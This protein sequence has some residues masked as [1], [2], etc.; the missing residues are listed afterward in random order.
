[1]TNLGGAVQFIKALVRV[2]GGQD[3]AN[4]RVDVVLLEPEGGGRGRGQWCE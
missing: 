1:M 4:V 2:D 3:G